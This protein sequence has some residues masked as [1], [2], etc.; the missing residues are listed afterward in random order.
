MAHFKTGSLISES[1]LP[2]IPY[3]TLSNHGGKDSPDPKLYRRLFIGIE[4]NSY[5]SHHPFLL[6]SLLQIKYQY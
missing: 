4:L 3:P 2:F 1:L 6:F 5:S